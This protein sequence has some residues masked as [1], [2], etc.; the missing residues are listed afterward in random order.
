MPP[1]QLL[2]AIGLTDKRGSLVR[3]LSG[4]Q[5]RRF[6]IVAAL[7]N[8]PLVVFLDEPTAG[9]DPQARRN[10]WEMIRQIRAEHAKTVLL[11]THYME[12]ASALCDR[13]LVMD[14][15]R[16]QA[17]GTPQELVDQ[18][19][20]GTHIRFSLDRPPTASLHELPGVLAVERAPGGQTNGYRL[21]VSAPEP[22]LTALIALAQREGVALGGL[23][24]K[25]ATLEDA[26][27][28][29]TGRSLRD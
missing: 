25:P 28:S 11:S 3:T 24:V 15:G 14:Y 13:V 8:D 23:E 7:V 21:R 2:A 6:S 22:C 16:V 20:E 5:A 19:A 1:R 4:G 27:L 29:L 12:E 17:L 18:H 10:L 9:L 26:F